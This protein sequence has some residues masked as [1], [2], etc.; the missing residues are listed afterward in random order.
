MTED[1]DSDIDGTEDGEFMRLLEQTTLSLQ[2]RTASAGHDQSMFDRRFDGG[3]SHRAVT[4][5]F[6]R[7]DLDLSATH[8]ERLRAHDARRETGT[9]QRSALSMSRDCFE[10]AGDSRQSKA[11]QVATTRSYRAELV[12]AARYKL[13]MKPRQMSENGSVG[14]RREDEYHATGPRSQSRSI[15]VSQYED[16]RRSFNTAENRGAAD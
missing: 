4:I 1:N 14:Q 8:C 15:E 11:G 5:I 3:Y 9:G 2:E 10:G 6:D 16:S 7:L 12:F 13:R